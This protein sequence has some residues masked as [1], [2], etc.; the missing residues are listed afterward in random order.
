M[1]GESIPTDLLVS[2]LHHGDSSFPSG[3]FAFS[4]GLE[5]FFLDQ[6][7]TNAAE[8]E[9]FIAD[10]LINRWISFD[11]VALR[12]SFAAA[13]DIALAEID[14]CVEI[15]TLS[16]A[17]RAGSKRAGRAVLAVYAKLGSKDGGHFEARPDPDQ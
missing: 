13:S 5:G 6:T 9:S 12:R 16:A 1:A 11:A 2:I 7:I 17:Q 8:L 15:A 10:L 4:S 14:R 3:G